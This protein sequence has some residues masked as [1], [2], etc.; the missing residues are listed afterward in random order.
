MQTAHSNKLKIPV[1]AAIYCSR[2]RHKVISVSV[3]GKGEKKMCLSCDILLALNV[4]F[5]FPSATAVMS[6]V[7]PKSPGKCGVIE[8]GFI[9]EHN[10]AR[11]KRH[12]FVS[13]TLSRAPRY[14]T[15]RC[16]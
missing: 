11:Q 13:F 5:K 8:G 2:E 6:A 4:Y 10:K 9:A 16:R 12:F 1:N 14:R 7:L 15:E 3:C